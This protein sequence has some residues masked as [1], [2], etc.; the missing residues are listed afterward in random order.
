MF[1]GVLLCFTFTVVLCLPSD[2]EWGPAF[3]YMVEIPDVTMDSRNIFWFPRKETYSDI[4]PH[5]QPTAK[6]LTA[7][8]SCQPTQPPRLLPLRSLDFL[9]NWGSSLSRFNRQSD[10]NFLEQDLG[11]IPDV[12]GS[13]QVISMVINWMIYWL[14]TPLGLTAPGSPDGRFDFVSAAQTKKLVHTE[15]QSA[16]W[17]YLCDVNRDGSPDVLYH[18]QPHGGPLATSVHHLVNWFGNL[19]EPKLLLHG[20][21]GVSSAGI[22]FGGGCVCRCLW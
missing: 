16:A 22:A 2:F 13:A 18:W 17:F 3:P 20:L 14:Y 12:G 7:N 4:T 15:E 10:G 21:P 19:Q 1:P 5:I 9:V 8:P 6:K 11:P